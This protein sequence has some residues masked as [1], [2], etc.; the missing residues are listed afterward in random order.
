MPRDLLINIR[1]KKSLTN[2]F[3]YRVALGMYKCMQPDKIS[4]TLIS[5]DFSHIKMT[6]EWLSAAES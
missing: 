4:F 2:R 3:V 5:T 6:T 1:Q